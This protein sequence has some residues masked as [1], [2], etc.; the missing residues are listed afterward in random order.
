MRRGKSMSEGDEIICRKG[1]GRVQGC[2]EGKVTDVW[3][4]PL[5]WW[6]VDRRGEVCEEREGYQW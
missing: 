3:A 2:G 5:R 6:F 1:E 4:R